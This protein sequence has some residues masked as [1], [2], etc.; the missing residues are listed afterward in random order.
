VKEEIAKV[1][2]PISDEKELINKASI[3]LDASLA[4]TINIQLKD[5][6]VVTFQGDLENTQY[7]G[8]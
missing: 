2:E 4:E 1:P 7:T 6:S 5:N 3:A 8:E